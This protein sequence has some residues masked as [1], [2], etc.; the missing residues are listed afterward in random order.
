MQVESPL[1]YTRPVHLNIRCRTNLNA[2]ICKLIPCYVTAECACVYP[3]YHMNFHSMKLDMFLREGVNERC[4]S[5][6][7]IGFFLVGWDLR[8]R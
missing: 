6:L 5:S 2:V 8:P 1:R 7:G 3:A 4:A